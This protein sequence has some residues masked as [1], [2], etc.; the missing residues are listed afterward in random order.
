MAKNLL[1]ASKHEVNLDRIKEL[2]SSPQ[3]TEKLFCLYIIISFTDKI[4]Y[5]YY[6]E[7]HCL[8]FSSEKTNAYI[9]LNSKRQSVIVTRPEIAL[10]LPLYSKFL[11]CVIM[12]KNS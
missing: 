10:H 12:K 3:T 1:R 9:Q 4:L 8:I 2:Y 7:E 11:L 5:S 6:A